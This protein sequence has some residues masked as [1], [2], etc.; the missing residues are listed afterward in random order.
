MVSVASQ[1]GDAELSQALKMVP[2]LVSRGTVNVE[3]FV[4]V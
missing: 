2:S 4:L 3:I 1:A